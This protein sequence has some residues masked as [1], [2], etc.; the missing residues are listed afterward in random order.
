MN[1]RKEFDLNMR[2]LKN[3]QEKS[4]KFNRLWLIVIGTLIISVILLLLIIPSV[5]M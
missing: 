5:K 4:N 2:E 1:I 3:N